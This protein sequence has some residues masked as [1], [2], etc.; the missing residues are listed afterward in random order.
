MV[1]I[2][3][4]NSSTRNGV[5]FSCAP[6]GVACQVTIAADGAVTATGGTV[7]ATLAAKT[8]VPLPSDL[9]DANAPAAGMVMIAAG[10]SSTRNGVVFSCAPGGA[11]CWVTIAADGTVT[12]TGGAVTATLSDSGDAARQ[13]PVDLPANLPVGQE[14]DAGSFTLPPGAILNRNGVTFSCPADATADCAVTVTADGKVTRTN[15]GGMVTVTLSDAGRAAIDAAKAKPVTLPDGLRL[16]QEPVAQEDFTIPAGGS[17]DKNGVTFSC[18]EGDYNCVVT[19]AA[20]GTVTKTGGMVTTTLSTAGETARTAG[21]AASALVVTAIT[22]YDN[23]AN[24]KDNRIG[25]SPI[26]TGNSDT[27]KY[28]PL[29]DS[30]LPRDSFSLKYNGREPQF[31]VKHGSTSTPVTPMRIPATAIPAGWMVREFSFE[32]NKGRLFLENLDPLKSRILS[33]STLFSGEDK[34][35][36]GDTYGNDGIKTTGEFGTQ[37][38]ISLN[39]PV[40]DSRTLLPED[41]GSGSIRSYKEGQEQLGSLFRVPGTFSCN[42]DASSTATC[43]VQNVNGKIKID[44]S[45]DASFVF[46]PAPV[47]GTTYNGDQIMATFT[48]LDT[49]YLRFGYW[50]TISGTGDNMVHTIDTFADGTGYGNGRGLSSNSVPLRGEATYSGAAAGIYTFQTGA[51]DTLNIYN[52]E[53]TADVTLKASFGDFGQGN[54]GPANQWKISGAVNKFTSVTNQSHDLSPWS[55]ELQAADMGTRGAGGIVAAPSIS[56]QLTGITGG[57]ET[58]PGTWS[59]VFYGNA[60]S[61]TTFSDPVTAAERQAVW[62]AIGGQGTVPNNTALTPDLVEAADDH[63]AAIVGEFSGNFSGDHPG[64]VVGVFGADKD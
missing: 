39:T 37:G 16:G 58:T 32:N 25:T 55:L 49:N 42:D 38:T 36:D 54:V 19:V 20:D 48:T 30:V 41:F 60:G 24:D 14:P 6:G 56:G 57:E 15:G 63:P 29:P 2:A 52:G 11:A 46:K 44:L 23:L 33:W 13:V 61:G 62:D 3:A 47:N 64:H 8:A 10:N 31:V 9:P 50:M 51:G 59:G 22:A 4:G 45:K 28:N 34:K 43:T 27:D 26:G 18:A 7:T 17:V 5:V 21:N 1:M 12:A 40:G 35:F 53:F